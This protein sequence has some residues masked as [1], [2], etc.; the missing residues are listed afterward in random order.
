M[1]GVVPGRGGRSWY[2]P[3]P[4]IAGVDSRVT[5]GGRGGRGRGRR[6]SPLERLSLLFG[7]V[8]IP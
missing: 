3:G 4:E 2:G 5:C 6:E 7:V 8:N 1:Q